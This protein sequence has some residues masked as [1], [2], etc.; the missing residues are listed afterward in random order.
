MMGMVLGDIAGSK[1]EFKQVDSYYFD[2]IEL[3]QRDSFFTDDTVMACATKYAILNQIKYA[4]A[5]KLFYKMFP[6]YS[7]G[8]RFHRWLASNN[9]K[10]YG[11]YGNGSAMRVGFIGEYFKSE[12][13]VIEQATQSAICT[14][15]HVEGIKG[16]VGTAMC[17]FYSKNGK[18]KKYIKDYIKSELQYQ[19]YSSLDELK[20]A[21]KND[22]CKETCQE[23]M[24]VSLSCFLLSNNYEDCLRKILSVNCDTDTCGCIAGGIAE[25]FYGKTGLENDEIISKYIKSTFLMDMVRRQI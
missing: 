11:S 18:E 15:D 21:T 3:F 19:L 2:G 14:H 6:N 4:D 17:T 13:Q 9:S 1:W 16:A 10:S 22:F 20:E 12:E 5:Y 24:P 23:S 25:N 8:L 7:Y